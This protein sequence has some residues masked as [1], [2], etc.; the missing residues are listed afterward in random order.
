MWDVECAFRKLDETGDERLFLGGK[1]FAISSVRC[2][3]VIDFFY[4]SPLAKI[5]P[6]LLPV[7]QSHTKCQPNQSSAASL[8][9]TAHFLYELLK[10][11]SASAP[12]FP[13]FLSMWKPPTEMSTTGY[14]YRSI[15]RRHSLSFLLR[16]V[17][18]VFAFQT[19]MIPVEPAKTEHE[20]WCYFCVK[21]FNFWSPF[22]RYRATFNRLF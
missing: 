7:A 1:Q 17:R 16:D 22:L 6:C 19:R 11:I 4:F 13:T 12:K 8:S 18:V 15:D 21:C 14:R 10:L 5:F 9:R 2:M 3:R 20:I